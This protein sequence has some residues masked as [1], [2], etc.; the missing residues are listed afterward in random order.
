MKTVAVITPVPQFGEAIRAALDKADYRTMVYDQLRMAQS[1]LSRG[2]IDLIIF[3]ADLTGIHAIRLIEEA[4]K[5]APATPLLVYANARQWEWEEDAYLLGVRHVLS[6][7][8]RGKLLNHFLMQLSGSVGAAPMAPVLPLL[9]TAAKSSGGKPLPALETLRSLSGVLMHSLNTDALLERVLA[10]LREVLGVNRAAIFLQKPAAYFERGSATPEDRSMRCACA[11]GFDRTFLD[12]FALSLYE[13][14]GGHLRRTGRILQAAEQGERRSDV[15]KE[16]QLMGTRV[17]VPIQDRETLLGVAT[18]DERL[19]GEPYSNEELALIFHMLEDIGLAVRNSWLHDQ[20]SH[21]HALVEDIL[22]QLTS[23]CIVAGPGP[24]ILNANVAARKI[25]LGEKASEQLA[26]ADLPQEL[27]SKVFA[28]LRSGIVEPSFRYQP[29]TA[30]AAYRVTVTPF[31]TNTAEQAALMMIEDVTQ[32]ERTQKL[33]IEASNLRL[34][35]SMAEH[36]AHEIGNSLVPLSTHQQLI[37][38][39]MDDPEFRES[40]S[41]A[42]GTSVKRITRLASQMVFLARDPQVAP[43][44]VRLS[45]L[46]LEA[47]R[48]AHTHHPDKVA[49]LNFEKSSSPW[50]VEGDPKALRHAFSEVLLNALQANPSDPE[51]SVDMVKADGENGDELLKIEVKDSG[52]GFTNEAV[53]KALDPFFSTRNVGLGLGLA[54][55]RRIIENHH[56]LIEIPEPVNGGRGVV[57]ISLPMSHQN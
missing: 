16:F 22:G 35:K 24:A 7:P 42:L 56:G 51:V 45:Q 8:V 17:A 9:P 52:K 13:G 26:F 40:L 47:F 41:T 10:S 50:T 19:T 3:D 54:V 29:K 48:E 1:L 32:I 36:L 57:R 46:I 33:E 49:R 34:I 23:G 53:E 18:F 20:L 21:N 43:Q 31:K 15:E 39:K 25:F 55:T 2:A 38:E 28:V 5:L 4:A 44:Q 12:Y 11:V 27:G 30:A 37:E 6:K 14:I